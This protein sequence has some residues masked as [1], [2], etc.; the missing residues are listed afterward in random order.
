M[1]DNAA[2]VDTLAEAQFQNGNYAEA[3]RLEA[4]VVRARPTDRFLQEQLR[5]FE[6]AAAKGAPAD[7]SRPKKP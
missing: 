2:F 1:P 6:A 4:Q 5:K 7:D 3:A